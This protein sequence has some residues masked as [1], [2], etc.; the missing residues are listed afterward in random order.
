MMLCNGGCVT[1][2]TRGLK[3]ALQCYKKKKNQRNDSKRHQEQLNVLA[4]YHHQSQQK[5][6]FKETLTC[7]RFTLSKGWTQK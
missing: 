5:K 2:G 6:I 4:E 1:I 7:E 3:C